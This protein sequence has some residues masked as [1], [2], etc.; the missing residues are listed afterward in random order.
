M[1]MPFRPPTIEP[2][3]IRPSVSKTSTKVVRRTLILFLHRKHRNKDL[4]PQRRQERKSFSRL[5]LSCFLD[6]CR[7]RRL[8]CLQAL[9]AHHVF[10][11]V[12]IDSNT[13]SWQYFA[14]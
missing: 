13:I 4:S 7:C 6:S 10:L 11:P 9:E 2:T 12:A 8:F 14:L 1:V 5:P 3:I